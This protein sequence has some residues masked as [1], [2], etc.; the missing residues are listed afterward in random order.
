M[1]SEFFALEGVGSAHD[2][3]HGSTFVLQMDHDIILLDYFPNAMKIH[4]F[5][6]CNTLV[7]G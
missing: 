3:F 2:I 6:P 1:A 4:K 7:M 5:I